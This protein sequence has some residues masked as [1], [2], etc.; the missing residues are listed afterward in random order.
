[1]NE[2]EMLI[3][4]L[5]LRARF[6]ALGGH[7]WSPG[8]AKALG[9]F[10]T[11]HGRSVEVERERD[12]RKAK[13][14]AMRAERASGYRPKGSGT[15]VSVHGELTKRHQAEWVTKADARPRPTVR[16]QRGIKPEGHTLAQITAKALKKLP[17]I[18]GKY[19]WQA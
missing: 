5:R 16:P 14:E 1:M 17:K 8:T 18:A 9:Q 11:K 6:Y 7:I 2:A 10:V 13:R 12:R 4:V 15:G 3:R 19:R